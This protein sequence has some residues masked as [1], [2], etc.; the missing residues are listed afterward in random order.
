VYYPSFEIYMKDPKHALGE[1]PL[2]R[3][4]KVELIRGQ[5]RKPVRSHAYNR[6]SH[7]QSLSKA[8]DLASRT[9]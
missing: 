6:D 7:T 2:T 5:V 9:T 4:T 1:M 3:D 8:D